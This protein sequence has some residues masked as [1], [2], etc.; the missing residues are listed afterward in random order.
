MPE[1]SIWVLGTDLSY[2][3]WLLVGVAQFKLKDDFSA[4]MDSLISA[5]LIILPKQLNWPEKQRCKM[6]ATQELQFYTRLFD[7]SHLHVQYGYFRWQI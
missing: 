5:G 1:L 6:T 3:N 2:E 7:Y 4:V